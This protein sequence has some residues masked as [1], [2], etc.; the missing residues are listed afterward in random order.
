MTRTF[1]PLVG[2]TTHPSR[3]FLSGTMRG[4]LWDGCTKV[5]KVSDARIVLMVSVAADKTL[6][7]LVG[8]LVRETP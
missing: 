4:C 6:R 5:G 7:F 3:P 8:A 2:T 1:C